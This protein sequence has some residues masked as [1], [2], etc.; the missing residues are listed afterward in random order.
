MRRR[1]YLGVLGA[2][3]LAGLAGCLDGLTGGGPGDGNTPSE[4]ATD[5]GDTAT[6]AGR[7]GDTAGERTLVNGVRVPV[8]DSELR[9]GAGIDAI[10]AITDPLFAADWDGLEMDARSRTGIEYT[11]R[12]A[13]VDDD[14]VLVVERDAVSGTLGTDE[15]T[16][17]ASAR[18]YPLRVLNWHEIVNDDYGGPLLVTYCPLCASGVTAVRR[19]NESRAVFG[20]S[21]LLY[22]NALVMYDR[23]TR[24]L[25]S[26]I[27]AAA[28]QGVQTGDTLTLVPSTLTTWG[29]FR[30]THPD[31]EVLLPP[32]ESNTVTGRDQTRNYDENPYAAYENT[33]RI[34]LGGE[35]DD[36]R[37]HPK[38]MVVGVAHDGV[39]RAYP[40]Q[41]VQD[42]GVV[43]DTVGDLPVVV[44]A[45]AEGTLVAYERTVDGE[46]LTFEREGA[47]LVG[48]GSRWRVVGG[49]AVDGPH[50]GRRLAQ[51][52]EVS[53]EFFFAWLD[54][55]P[56]TEVYGL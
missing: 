22:R 2:G 52:N 50:E 5:G 28:I 3:G 33:R 7:D 25:W 41:P 42:A 34:G 9:R 4:S 51:A 12:P 10:P 48:G 29:E 19:V 18:A 1:R 43:N 15:P 14:R 31:G 56:E 6:A 54:F 37:L 21:G 47:F 20:V 55:H 35:F 16:G 36:D 11:S 17:L 26:Q 32:P 53:P 46:P 40:L 24:S 38:T 23:Q 39:A 44:A 8:P 13:L 27:A 49:R 45:T 30:A